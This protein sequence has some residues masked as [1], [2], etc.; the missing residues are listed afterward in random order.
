MRIMAGEETVDFFGVRPRAVRAGARQ[1]RG[2]PDDRVSGL[3]E[4]RAG[5]QSHADDRGLAE[6]SDVPVV[7]VDRS[8]PDPLDQV[9]TENQNATAVL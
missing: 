3:C 6:R 1:R 5:P 9:G 4:V 8:T 7:L 2:V